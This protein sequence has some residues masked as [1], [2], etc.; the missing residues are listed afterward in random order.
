[1]QLLNEL[2]GNFSSTNFLVF[3]QQS[4]WI[5]QQ[6]PEREGRFVRGKLCKSLVC[7]LGVLMNKCAVC[8]LDYGLPHSCAGIA[9]QVSADETA[10]RRNFASHLSVILMKHSRS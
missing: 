9:P 5:E 4:P 10:P 2:A 6:R 7:L 1:M 8:G 3:V